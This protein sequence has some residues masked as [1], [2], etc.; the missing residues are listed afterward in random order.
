MFLKQDLQ[1]NIYDDDELYP[2]AIYKTEISSFAIG[3][4][5]S[6]E[7]LFNLCRDLGDAKGNLKFYVS[8]SSVPVNSSS[9][10][11]V[12]YSSI[13]HVLPPLPAT[14]PL[15]IKRRTSR[16]RNGSVS[17]TSESTP[18]EGG[19]DADGENPQHRETSRPPA[20][21]SQ[22]Q[23]ASV[24]SEHPPSP[25]RRPSLPQYPRPSSP[26]SSQPEPL[27]QPPQPSQLFDWQRPSRKDE[28][29]GH[30]PLPP[31][32]TGSHSL[33][34]NRPS[35]PLNEDTPS[36]SVTQ[37]RH[38]HARS[39][40]D[41]APEQQHAPKAAEFHTQTAEPV[42]RPVRSREN[43]SLTKLRPEL[44]R[45]NMRE[46]AAKQT[47][48]EEDN[49]WEIVMPTT[50]L[51]DEP[52]PLGR[53]RQPNRYNKPTSPFNG[54]PIV[55]GSS[56][57]TPSS[58]STTTLP[59]PLPLQSEPPRPS[60]QSQLRA[61]RWPVSPNVLVSWKGEEG[62]S[63]KPSQTS[64]A[65]ATSSWQNTGSRLNKST[66][67][68]MDSLRSLNHTTA[69]RNPP[70]ALPVLT[71]PQ[72]SPFFPNG[73]TNT[74]LS[75]SGTPKSYEPPRTG[76]IRPLPHGPSAS[77]HH[78]SSSSGHSG[79]RGHNSSSLVNLNHDPYPRPQSAAGDATYS[80]SSSRRMQSPTYGTNLDSGEFNRSPR[81]VSPSRPFHSP[82][83]GI[84][85]PRPRPNHHSDRSDR[86]SASGP[87][88]VN[89]SP[90]HTPISPQSSTRYES[91]ENGNAVAELSPP[92][93]PD[94]S[95][96][97][98]ETG[99]DLTLKQ[100]DQAALKKM[101]NGWDQETYVSKAPAQ[102]TRS[103]SPPIP[104]NNF[105]TDSYLADDDE[106]EG[107]SGGTWIVRPEP[108]QM[109]NRPP[110]TVHIEN[111][112]NPPSPDIGS[113]T[114]Q[115]T[116]RPAVPPKDP[117]PSSYRSPAA[118]RLLSSTG[119]PES[120]FIDPEGDNWARPPPENIYEHLEKFFPTHDLDK[121]VIEATASGDTSPT[122]SVP[123]AGMIPP[124]I[125][126]TDGKTT[127]MKAKKSIRIVAQEHKKL[128]DRTS[129]AAEHTAYADNMKRKRSTKLWGS[130]LE[131]VTTA[132][133]AS[134][135]SLPESPSSGPGPSMFFLSLL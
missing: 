97:V 135:S 6:N 60:M 124:P 37:D 13:P 11:S 38:L 33:S 55:Y 109:S 10:P 62:S 58:V 95:T 65:N 1:L 46:R 77:D 117:P 42:L 8:Q 74:N 75:I 87:E 132:R 21:T 130:K 30:A 28:K 91:S 68:S 121:P 108:M 67:K 32:P 39:A 106:E 66:T 100:E 85:G 23:G 98:R 134:S 24:T 43:P 125:P 5:L 2:Y 48:D 56:R 7:R 27:P 34:P 26:R 122:S 44:S 103:F 40:S 96:Y 115:A 79:I 107:G 82:G 45:D 31:I 131:E 89:T 81:T 105:S 118:A 80:P 17:S 76:M 116:A 69:R 19:Y 20:R 90:P 84:P 129:R 22:S 12:E 133:S 94:T 120:T 52:S 119:R 15:R 112:T 36:L 73:L 99:S 25:P 41:A 72:T 9:T 51:T 102:Q 93:S 50:R 70:P 71:R 86:S 104:E 54:R 59:L 29:Y 53:S 127:K 57:P 61:G 128:I 110:L 78:T 101:L 63:R 88:T 16:S 111:P 14:N 83:I 4:A 64:T 126:A 123:P 35:F 114:T 49:S 92:S 3:E 18:L 47:Y 113:S